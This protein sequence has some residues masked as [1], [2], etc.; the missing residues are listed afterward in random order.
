[1]S[2][3]IDL[4]VVHC[5]ATKPNQ[6]TTM[7]DIRNWHTWP[8]YDAQKNQH[9]YQGRWYDNQSL[10]TYLQNKT[11]NGWTDIGYHFVNERD[12]V[13]KV[14]RPIE[15][16]GAHCKGYNNN[17]IGYC[18]VG[19]LSETGQTENNFTQQQWQTFERDITDIFKKYPNIE[20]CGHRDLS[21]DVD[22]DGEIEEHE[23]IK[24]CPGFSVE[25]WLTFNPIIVDDNILEFGTGE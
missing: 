6:M 19:G 15:I 14:G 11:G 18:L 25:E 17:S 10:P 24:D 2:R 13:L 21:P 9:Y 22:G 4:L 23:W 16:P 12:G 7:E 8:R 5:S 20:I 1:M 3:R